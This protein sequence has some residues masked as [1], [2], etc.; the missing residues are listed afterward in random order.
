V[1]ALFAYI[2]EMVVPLPLYSIEVM[3]HAYSM[4]DYYLGTLDAYIHSLVDP[5]TVDPARVDSV[6]IYVWLTLFR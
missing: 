2:P 6:T 3:H 4:C 1:G 5:F